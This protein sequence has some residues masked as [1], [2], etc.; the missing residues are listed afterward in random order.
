M[1]C[2]YVW[3]PCTCMA[4]RVKKRA[5]DPLEQELQKPVNHLW[6]LGCEPGSSVRKTTLN[7]WATFQGPQGAGAFQETYIKTCLWWGISC[8]NLTGPQA[9]CKQAPFR[10]CW[11]DLPGWLAIESIRREAKCLPQWG[12]YPDTTR[13]LISISLY[14]WASVVPNPKPI[15]L[16]RE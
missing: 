1:F 16:G 5:S 10:V 7:P 3:A 6:L 4:H 15:P 11:K 8:A 14:L 12:S 2:I 13:V 9:A